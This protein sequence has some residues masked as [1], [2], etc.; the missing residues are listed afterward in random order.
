MYCTLLCKRPA[1]FCSRYFSSGCLLGGLCFHLQVLLCTPFVLIMSCDPVP[2]PEALGII[3]PFP[4]SVF[5]SPPQCLDCGHGCLA[6]RSKVPHS[7]SSLGFIHAVPS[8]GEFL[9]SSPSPASHI[10]QVDQ[11]CCSFRC[12]LKC[13]FL[14]KLAFTPSLCEQVS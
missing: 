3:L 6:Q 4:R 5:S 13:F 7:F 11:T 14:G 12:Q 2:A 10:F 1:G 8:C 9:L